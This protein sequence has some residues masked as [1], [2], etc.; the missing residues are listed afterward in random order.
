ML[1][2]EQVHHF[3]LTSRPFFPLTFSGAWILRNFFQISVYIISKV[4]VNYFC[5]TK[6]VAPRPKLHLFSL[7][8]INL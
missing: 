7:L 6:L 5:L 3:K 8:E 4:L 1:Q 2:Q